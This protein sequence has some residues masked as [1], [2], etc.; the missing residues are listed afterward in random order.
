M[1]FYEYYIFF[2]YINIIFKIKVDIINLSY[3]TKYI[4]IIIK[5]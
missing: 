2:I 4:N 5:L 1:N 3:I